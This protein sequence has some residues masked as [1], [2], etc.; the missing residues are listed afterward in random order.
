MT[1]STVTSTLVFLYLADKQRYANYP[2]R[3]VYGEIITA[4][5]FLFLALSCFVTLSSDAVYFG[6]LL[7]A[8][9]MATVG[10]SYTQNGSIAVVSLYEPVY[11]Q[12]VMVGQAFAGIVP[13]LGSILSALS[14][15]TG[16]GTTADST[17]TS[18]SPSELDSSS[19]WAQWSSFVY[20]II[21]TV[22]SLSAVFLYIFSINKVKVL[23]EPDEGDYLRYQDELSDDQFET[24]DIIES[25]EEPAASSSEYTSFLGSPNSKPKN[26][27]S[28]PPSSPILAGGRPH[29]QRSQTHPIAIVEDEEAL[30]KGEHHTSVSLT[31]LSIKLRI[32]ATTVFLVFAVTLA[33]PVFASTVQSNTFGIPAHIYIPVV[34]FVWNFGDL[35]GRV[36]CAFPFFIIKR[37]SYFLIYGIGRVL[38]IP[39]FLLFTM[40]KDRSDISYLLLHLLFGI[41]NGHLCSCAFIQFPNYLDDTEREAGGGFMTLI[42]SFGLTTGSLF[43]FVLSILVNSISK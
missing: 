12:A 6:F 8:M 33:Y 18:D 11:T 7:F 23:H 9:F 24:A 13:P 25:Q 38:F 4:V 32:P 31:K 41:T 28:S 26:P 5:V 3:I 35:I 14:Y 20:F 22:L 29:L 42:L 34:F 2:R 40:S 36:L 21:A 16:D 39:F 1:I 15:E 43:S 10:T 17:S 19:S 27:K 30:V 37:D